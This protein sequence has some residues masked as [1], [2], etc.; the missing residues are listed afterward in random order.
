MPL[1]FH[2]YL[3]IH[4]M[5]GR[6][7]KDVRSIG[8]EVTRNFFNSDVFFGKN[9]VFPTFDNRVSS[10]VFSLMPQTKTANK[11]ALAFKKKRKD[12]KEILY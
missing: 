1:Y 2:V 7:Y 3:I 11:L 4:S 6:M 5:N 9:K 10:C 8:N 12:R